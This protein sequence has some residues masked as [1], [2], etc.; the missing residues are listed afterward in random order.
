MPSALA[1]AVALPKQHPS[2]FLFVAAAAGTGMRRSELLALKWTRIDFATT[3]ITVSQSIEHTKELGC[4][5]TTPK[6]KR[7]KRSFQ[8][9]LSLLELVRREHDRHKRIVAGIPDDAGVDLSLI[10]LPPNTLL[11][12]RR[13][14]R[15]RND[16]PS[17]RCNV[18]VP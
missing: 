15:P 5:F 11:F 18:F 9:D 6:T 4:R 2:L 14:Y 3:S 16:P 1:I 13:G 10:K 8:I 7:G 12:P 17:G